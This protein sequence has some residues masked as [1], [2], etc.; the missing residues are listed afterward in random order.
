MSIG[1]DQQPL[2]YHN[3][4]WLTIG[5]FDGVHRGHQ[6]IIR[7]LVEESHKN[8]NPA[9]VAT[10][11]PHPAK[12]LRGDNHPYYLTA[13]EEKNQILKSLG[14]DTILTLHFDHTL[15]SQSAE[16]FITTLHQQLKFSCLLI[17]HD[18]RLGANRSG[19]IHTLTQLGS[20]LGYCVQAIEPYQ[21]SSEIISSSLIRELLKAGSLIRANDLLGRPYSV[22]GRIIHGDGRGKHI[23][24]PTANLEIWQ[25]RL[26]PAIGVYAA[27]AQLGSRRWMSVVNIGNRPTFYEK[28][29]Q[30]TVEAHLLDFH[31]EI[32]DQE[33][34][35]FFTRRIRPEKKFDNAESL[36]VQISQ[37]IQF[38]REVLS[39]EFDQTNLPA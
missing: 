13:P 6:A 4:S 34:R 1:Q 10:F 27:I 31:E 15:A 32:Y 23:G 28:P 20:Q 22:S 2:H 24:L 36:M 30:Q 19:D 26:M 3:G 39:D 35:L 9:I 11:F 29:F 7:M 38:A 16:T 18:F 5:S 17:G 8:G 12:V 14:V 25:E 21:S 33:M 37:D